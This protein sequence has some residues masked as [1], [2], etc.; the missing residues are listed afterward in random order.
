MDAIT[1]TPAGEIAVVDLTAG[2]RETAA[3]L[4]EE[5]GCSCSS[6]VSL[7]DADG[8]FGAI[9]FWLDDNGYQVEPVNPVATMVA[10]TFEPRIAQNFYGTAVFVSTRG[11][12]CAALS[13]LQVAGIL[14]LAERARH[15]LAERAHRAAATV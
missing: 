2:G 5:I 14:M 11:E 6:R 4:N 13:E 9:E 3:G 10:R 8:A 7:T 12:S 1:I 15:R